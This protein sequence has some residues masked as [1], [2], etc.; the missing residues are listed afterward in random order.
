MPEPETYENWD[1]RQNPAWVACP[2]CGERA[3]MPIEP[4]LPSTPEERERFVTM[5][6]APFARR[7]SSVCRYAQTMRHA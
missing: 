1:A 7:L 5:I 3:E 4:P 6:V 2:T